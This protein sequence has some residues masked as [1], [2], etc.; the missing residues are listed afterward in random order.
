M[1]TVF[2][3]FRDAPERRAA[4]RAPESLGRYRLFG[5]DDVQRHGVGVR[6]NLER[7]GRP[8]LWARTLDRTINAALHRAGVP[9]D[10]RHR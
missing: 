5:L 10:A 2:Y 7:A 9:T 4:L 6:H 8:P 3:A 1:P